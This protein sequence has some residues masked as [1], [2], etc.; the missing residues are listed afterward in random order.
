MGRGE[1]IDS[2]VEHEG[3]KLHVI[4]IDLSLVPRLH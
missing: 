2:L 1:K 3:K 4:M